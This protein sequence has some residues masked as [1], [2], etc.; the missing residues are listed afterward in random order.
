MDFQQQLSQVAERYRAQ[1]YRVEIRP[2]PDVLPPFAKDFHVEIIASRAGG[3]VLVSAKSSQA[4]MV[5]D[6]NLPMYAEVIERHP[7]WRFDIFVLGPHPQAAPDERPVEEQTD[8]QIYKSLDDAE[9]MLRAGFSAQAVIAAWAA[10]ESA[11]RRVLRSQGSKAGWGTSPRTM[12]N[13][14]VS[15]GSLSNSEFHDLEGLFELRNVIVHGF[16]APEIDPNAIKFLVETSRRLLEESHLAKQ[17][18]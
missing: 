17:T 7:G 3:N 1:G 12:L 9:G 5:A 8:A 13:E 18:A 11:M 14:L 10:L 2:G 6:A 16:S 15:T 4:E